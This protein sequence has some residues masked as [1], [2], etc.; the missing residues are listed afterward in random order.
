MST[1]IEVNNKSSQVKSSQMYWLNP[2]KHGIVTKTNTNMET[3]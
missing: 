2:N 1:E 3:N